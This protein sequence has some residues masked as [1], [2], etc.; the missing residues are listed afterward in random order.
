LP[1]T[2]GK[3]YIC[4]VG[5]GGAEGLRWQECVDRGWGVGRAYLQDSPHLIS[6]LFLLDPHTFEL[7]LSPPDAVVVW[8]RRMC[9]VLISSHCMCLNHTGLPVGLCMY[10]IKEDTYIC[11]VCIHDS[12]ISVCL[13]TF[14]QSVVHVCLSARQAILLV[15]P[16]GKLNILL[17]VHVCVHT[18]IIIGVFDKFFVMHR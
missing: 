17:V 12:E 1:S 18:W 5:G 7:C 16:S 11:G 4:H 3:Q 8:H 10:E 2:Y 15:I 13:D 14:R 6:S 9:E